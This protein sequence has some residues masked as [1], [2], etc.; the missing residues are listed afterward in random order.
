MMPLE[1]SDARKVAAAATSSGLMVRPP[2][3]EEASAAKKS[4][5]LSSP[6]RPARP[7]VWTGP[8]LSALTLMLRPF[9]SCI[10]EVL[11]SHRRPALRAPRG[12]QKSNAVPAIVC[13]YHAGIGAD[14]LRQVEL[15]ELFISRQ[16]VTPPLRHIGE[17]ITG[18]VRCADPES[19]AQLVSCG[20]PVEAAGRPAMNEQ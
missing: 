20:R 15:D 4:S 6:A 13:N 10:H 14:H 12:V 9:S 5:A 3:I 18:E 8:G 16:A 17:S 11:K 7:G 1:S 2:G 19:R